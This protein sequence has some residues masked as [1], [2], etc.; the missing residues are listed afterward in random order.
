[1]RPHPV[2]SDGNSEGYA[3]TYEDGER[4]IT[5]GP[6]PTCGALS[7]PVSSACISHI[8]T[9]IAVWRSSMVPGFMP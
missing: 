5:L 4:Q 6:N 3:R 9:C 2:R 7:Q 1:M 8:I